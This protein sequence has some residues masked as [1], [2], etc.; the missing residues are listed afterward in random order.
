[1]FLK[2]G[3]KTSLIW[4]DDK[5]SYDQL[6]QHI[7]F[8]VTLFDKNKTKKVAIFS[9]NKPQWAYVFYAAWKNDSIVVPIDF[10]ATADEV[11]YILND[12]Q[13]EVIFISEKTA[14]VFNEV[15]EQLTHPIQIHVLE[16]QDYNFKDYPIATLPD[17]DLQKTA[18]IIYTSGT[19]GSPKGVM[20][21]YDS[22]LANIEAVVH[23]IPI[24][25][26]DRNVMALLPMHH[27]FPLMGT[28]IAPLYAGG[29]IAF[30]PSMVSEDII[31]TLQNNKIN[32]IIG[33]PRLYDAIRKGIMDKI[34]ANLIAR[35]LFKIA[36]A[37]N[38]RA[39]SKRIFKT[40]HQKFGGYVD[41]MVCGG[42]KLNEDV[43]SDFKTLGFEMLEGFGM[44]EAAPMITFTR[45]GKWKIGSAGQSMPYLE[46]ST[47]N[48]EMVAKGRNIMQGYYN[49]PEETAQVLK[50]GWLHTGDLGYLDEEGFVHIT[51]RSKEIIVLSNGKNINPEEIESKLN[52]MSDCI[53]EVGVFMMND[54]LQAAIYPDFKTLKE[55]S[56]VNLDEMFRWDV[57]DQYNRKSTPYKKISKFILLK[58]E[59]PKTRLGKI[60]RFKLNEL[61]SANNTIKKEKK[62]GPDYEEY[63]VI[64]DFMREQMKTEVMPDDHFE[65]DLGL[66]S[67]DQISFLTFLQSTFGIEVKEDILLHHPTIEKIAEYM[68]EKKNRLV[69]EAVKW[70]EIFKEKVDLKLPKSWFTQNLFKNTSKIFLKSYF[71]LKG[72]GAENLPNGPFILAP[73]HQS[74]YDGL[75]VSAFLKNRI[76]KNTYF[77]AKEKHVRYRWVRALA[78]RN[79]VIIMDINRDLKHSLQKLAGVLKKGK[80]IMIFPEGTRTMDGQIG[81]FK[82]AFAILSR[83]MNVPIVPVSIKGAYEALPKGRLIPKPLKKINIKFHKPVFPK[84]HDYDT[85]MDAVFKQLTLELAENYL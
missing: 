37:V 73:N 83:E 52:A 46:V 27:I 74:F 51:G 49:R 67:L 6:L 84:G 36:K 76:M 75:F 42:A 80:N 47:K 33:V 54:T 20:L 13:P 15:K 24:Y 41:Y 69:V 50:D 72:E 12:C 30:A 44:T 18:V 3:G 43:A 38:S 48:G 81:K 77:Y 53:A 5:I 57:I 59:L 23:D 26:D 55:K 14:E 58:D 34:N 66:D 61:A 62:V 1:M 70:S 65:I 28:L 8:Y 82:K 78:N 79:N 60:Q 2:P 85:L 21:S 63:Q 39:F 32:I 11:A 64:R 17:P 10:M 16:N 40:V 7:N 9:P 68:R 29:T 19:T 25:T 22:L 71:K 35:T 4:Q 45:P 56:I 31:A